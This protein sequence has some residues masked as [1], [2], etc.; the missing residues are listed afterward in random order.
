ML[1]K[2]QDHSSYFLH[3]FAIFFLSILVYI[4]HIWLLFL[5]H[6]PEL[7][8]NIININSKAK[9]E[10]KQRRVTSFIALFISS[11]L[12]KSK[13]KNSTDLTGS[14]ELTFTSFTEK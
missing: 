6:Y 14:F 8:N 9:K 11:F 1:C 13:K 4:P 3:S 10:E 7:D 5:F 2:W 12:I